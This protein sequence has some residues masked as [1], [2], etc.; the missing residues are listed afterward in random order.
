MSVKIP[1][2]QDQLTPQG[3]ET[4]QAR[5]PEISPALGGAIARFGE[6]GF[7]AA[8]ALEEKRAVDEI[9]NNGAYLSERT[10]YFR[11]RPAD[12]ARTSV[13]GG[14]VTD[15][16]G[17]P[18][19]DSGGNA[20]TVTQQTSR[21]FDNWAQTYLAGIQTAKARSYAQQHVNALRTSVLDTAMRTEA[22]LDIQNRSDK[23]DQAIQNYSGI[24]GQDATQAAEALQQVKV[25]IANAGLDPHT[26]FVKTMQAQQQI[27]I[28]AVQG[29][30][31]RN[32]S[33]A[34]QALQERFGVVAA[35]GPDRVIGD[36]VAE[37]TA[38]ALGKPTDL[39]TVGAN[40]Q[41]VLNT[42]NALPQDM[43][44]QSVVLSTGISNNLE[45][46]SLVE[47][48]IKA[49]RSR[50]ANVTIL[51]VGSRADIAPMNQ[52]LEEI[53]KANG[54]TFS[55]PLRSGADGVHPAD[56]NEVARP[57]QSPSSGQRGTPQTYQPQGRYGQISVP[58]QYDPIVQSASSQYG[59]PKEVLAWVLQRESNWNPNPASNGY[60]V[61]GM[62]QFK[63]GT[64]AEMGVAD[65]L[66]PNQAIPGAARYLAQ[67][68]QRWGSWES[69]IAHYGTFSTG[70]GAARDA[71]VRRDF[72]RYYG[73]LDTGGDQGSAPGSTDGTS[74]RVQL[75]AA[76]APANNTGAPP[77]PVPD[78]LR[79]LVAHIDP[80]HVHTLLNQARVGI[81]ALDVQ[82]RRAE[83]DRLR[84]Q[85]QASDQD[86]TRVI[87]DV[88]GVG[89]NKSITAQ[90]VANPNGPYR[91]LTP[92]ARLQ[93]IAFLDRKTKPDPAAVV[94]NQTATQLLASMRRPDGD[95][96]RITDMKPIYDAYIA[97][98]L[99]RQDFAFLQQQF[100]DMGTDDGQRLS[101][102]VKRLV[103]AAKPMIDKSN[104]LMGQIDQ[105]GPMSLMLYERMINER[106]AEYRKTGKNPYDLLNPASGEYLGAAS[107]IGRYQHNINQS[108]QQLQQNLMRPPGTALPAPPGAPPPPPRRSLFDIFG[109]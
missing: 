30:T 52:R 2:Y 11:N 3:F 83:A 32:P 5:P 27:A 100:K 6:A 7:T 40:P 71:E 33:Q 67:L 102:E 76:P 78:D 90:Q 88:E 60:D 68:K 103:D 61:H 55:G 80:Q 24:A 53:A 75:A 18:V 91:N 50:G 92:Q 1:I 42:I 14:Q 49:L 51:G 47:D 73:A 98:M 29:A 41:A 81:D 13:N 26:R 82:Q 17:Q 28:A 77:V 16:Q 39:T 89:D 104:P 46:I 9:A 64:A 94:S 105:T 20:V 31:Q 59:V 84:Q 36:S 19:L 93:M 15:G 38:R 45:Q 79:G 99:N 57:F 8:A 72:Q 43:K 56:Y 97:G 62:A 87:A 63:P 22:H 35:S 96:N 65:P 69:A 70:Q 12:L 23:V 74:P 10:A 37:G 58:A 44:G 25:L 108:V 101:Q 95:P 4:Q 86:E 48:Q 107:V 54:A 66:D 34:Y 21:E 85:K 106:I 109:R